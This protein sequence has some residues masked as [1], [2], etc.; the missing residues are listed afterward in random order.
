MSRQRALRVV[1]VS[2][3][4]ADGQPSMQ[5][6]ADML[7]RELTAEGVEVQTWR[8]QAYVGGRVTARGL[9]KW[10]GYVDK[11][12]LYPPHLRNLARQH[13]DTPT[14]VHV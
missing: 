11:Y 1:L 5:R 9:G 14:V 6:F 7:H 12:V 10:L 4:V 2:N 13:A 3:Y 8:P